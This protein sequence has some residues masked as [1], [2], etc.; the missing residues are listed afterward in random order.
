MCII[1]DITCFNRKYSWSMYKNG[2][3]QPLDESSDTYIIT[4]NVT[5]VLAVGGQEYQCKCMEGE[6]CK[7]FTIWGTLTH[8]EE[9]LSPHECN[10]IF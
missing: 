3:N 7:Q 10:H 8:P 9:L 6:D 4:Q 5:S 1:N 2:T